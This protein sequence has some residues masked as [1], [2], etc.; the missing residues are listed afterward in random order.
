MKAPFSRRPRASLALC[1][2]SLLP[3]ATSTGDPTGEALRSPAEISRSTPLEGGP[4]EAGA[5]P[6]GVIALPESIPSA[7]AVDLRA[8]EAVVLRRGADGAPE[9]VSR[10]FVSFG[11]GGLRK[12][13]EGDEKTPLGVYHVQ[14]HLPGSGLPAIYGAG[15]LPLD[16]PNVWDRRLERTGSGIWI[17]G[18][19]RSLPDLP[20]Q[21]SR[22]C[23]AF[24]D[25][26]FLRVL[27]E[28]E[29]GATPVLIAET[30]DWGA[31]EEIR[32]TASELRAAI[33]NWRLDWESLD[34]DRYL[35]H[36]ASD[37]RSGS[38]S[39]RAFEDHKR[40]V[41]AGRQ[42]IRVRLSDVELYRYP[43]EED[44]FLARYVQSYESDTYRGTSVKVQ[45][46]TR[47]ADGWTIVQ[48]GRG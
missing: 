39:R 6:V 36:Y 45:F 15:A 7:I 21:V 48:E 32:A 4:G 44:L 35:A 19:D 11:K 27:D 33:E 9:I 3:A 8:N 20:S 10:H 14:R 1:A 13:R 16:Y 12:L 25:R 43:G 34:V 2:L 40:R 29:V 30:L 47:S 24:D 26:D 46:W 31:P 17:H 5:L 22:G 42:R 18:S 28:V 23:L 37:F 38:M 41:G